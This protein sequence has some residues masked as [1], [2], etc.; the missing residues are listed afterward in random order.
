MNNFV[1]NTYCFTM[2]EDKSDNQDVL[3]KVA[4][5]EDMLNQNSFTFFDVVKDNECA[6]IIIQSG[7][8]EVIYHKGYNATQETYRASRIMFEMSGVDSATAREA[9]RLAAHKLPVKT[10]FIIK[11]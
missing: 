11:G 3:N 1:I 7:I 9:M 5:F 10:K 8:R 2:L 6:K 4:L